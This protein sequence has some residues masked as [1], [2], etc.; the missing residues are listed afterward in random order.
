MI[1][2]NMQVAAKTNHR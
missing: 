1:F 2:Q